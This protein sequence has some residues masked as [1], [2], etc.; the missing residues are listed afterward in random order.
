MHADEIESWTY[1]KDS[2]RKLKNK[3]CFVK[4]KEL[5]KHGNSTY[6]THH[7]CTT[8]NQLI[9][10]KMHKKPHQCG[11]RYYKTCTDLFEEGHKC[12]MLPNTTKEQ[13][14]P[15]KSTDHE[16]V[17]NESSIYFLTLSAHK[18]TS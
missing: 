17:Q 6:H 3:T 1:C 13:I 18:M 4:H 9:N 15:V 16:F 10:K 2:N 12:Y 14:Q 8:C 5:T 11:E 7:K